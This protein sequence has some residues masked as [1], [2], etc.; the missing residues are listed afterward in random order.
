MPS[1]PSHS[2]GVPLTVGWGRDVIRV[3]CS[4]GDWLPLGGISGDEGGNGTNDKRAVRAECGKPRVLASRVRASCPLSQ[5]QRP[6]GR[7]VDHAR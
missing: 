6:E 5:W 2:A 3:D 4:S 1:S 7:R